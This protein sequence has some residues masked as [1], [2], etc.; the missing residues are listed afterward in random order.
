MEQAL[1]R[2]RRGFGDTGRTSGPAM[3][4]DNTVMFGFHYRDGRHPQFD[5]PARPPGSPGTRA[6]HAPIDDRLSTVDRFGRDLVLLGADPWRVAAAQISVEDRV[7]LRHHS[8][9]AGD[10]VAADGAVLV[11]PDGF[12]AWRCDNSVDDHT[13]TL[14]AALRSALT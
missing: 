11:R 10:G 14:R 9:H 6:P 7:P 8:A 5:D 4:D 13:G 2:H 1:A 12:I 3:V